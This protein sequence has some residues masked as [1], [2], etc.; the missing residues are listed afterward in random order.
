[1]L[2]GEHAVLHHHPCLVTA[3][4]LRTFVTIDRIEGPFLFIETPGLKEQEQTYSLHLNDLF[5]DQQLH[6]QTKFIVASIRKMFSK[7]DLQHGLKIRTTGPINSYGLGSS[8]AVTVACILALANLFQI[9]IDTPELFTL[10][11]SAV[12]EVQ[13]VG[14][15][16]D[17]ASAIHGGTI[18]YTPSQE[19]EILQVENLPIVI[20]YSGAKVSTTNLVHEV[21]QL[22]KQF[23]E[24]IA[25]V[26][27]SMGNIAVR[28]RG[29]ILQK[30]W[31]LVG[32]LADMNQGLLESLGVSTPNL[33]KP[34]LAA[35][36][37]GS[38]GAKLSGAGGGDC[39]YAIVAETSQT[40]VEAAIEQ[41]GAQVLHLATNT[42][43]ARLELENA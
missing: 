7:F 36:Q 2:F 4:D 9:N 34:I 39:M 43:G 10:A 22:R 31:Q 5:K 15:G 21:E 14:S 3:V 26:F 20:A 29:A 33:Q 37:S 25:P 1:M 12:L 16:F 28:A 18:F 11:Y 32:K 41:S 13:T 23:P 19:V 30:N 6:P 40:V 8:S 27:N 35:R 38:F 17:V 24:I 42:D